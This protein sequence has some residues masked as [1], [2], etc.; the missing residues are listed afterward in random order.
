MARAHA[1]LL[2][3]L[4]IAAAGFWAHREVLDLPIFGLD[5]QAA[6][7]ASRIQSFPDLVGTFTEVMMDG[8]LSVGDFYRPVGNLF[9]AF[10]YAAWGMEDRGYQLTSMVLWCGVV[11]VLYLLVRRMLGG[12]VW[13]GPA[14][15]ALFFA[16]HPVALSI[17]P[18]PARRTETL[19]LLF[20]GLSLLS[21][22]VDSR[23][24]A[25]RGNL[26]A[27]V[28]AM[29]A[30]ASKETA[31]VAVPL[32][33]LYR[34]L[35]PGDEHALDRTKAAVAA[36]LPAAA[37]TAAVLVVRTGVIGGLGGY[38][39]G[40]EEPYFVRLLSFGPHY[41]AAIFTSGAYELAV[42]NERPLALA[43]ALLGVAAMV[44]LRLLGREAGVA[45]STAPPALLFAGV[46][47]VGTIVLSCTSFQVS[48]RYMLPMVFSSAMGFGAATEAT[49]QAL[50][51][52]SAPARALALVACG[53][54]AGVGLAALNGSA[55]TTRYPELQRGARTQRQLLT[56]TAQRIE[57]SEPY[58]YIDAELM[59]RV[60]VS[61]RA[62]DD[63]WLI[64]PW[65]LQA[66]LELVV[67]ERS[68]KVTET[69]RESV[70][71]EEFWAVSI[72]PVRRTDR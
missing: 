47:L 16:L 72:N 44:L 45:G 50:R 55:L 58:D 69:Q 59:R 4:V 23:G 26:L 61:A 46:W 37:L 27:G 42:E 3:P 13:L 63:V 62:V 7:I 43:A 28:F 57:A 49:V 1:H 53:M 29:L 36:C 40:A 38:H 22:R 41:I 15:A 12:G 51:T 35:Q 54:L 5:G 52:G 2:V 67:P 66:W 39:T 33:F 14:L 10:D 19:G 56:A 48:P 21:L 64:G 6:I 18:Y 20:I 32:I 34:V 17:L 11:V 65:G 71:Y 30:V 9:L 68:Y 25:R 24:D 8:R 70:P 31:A 60:P